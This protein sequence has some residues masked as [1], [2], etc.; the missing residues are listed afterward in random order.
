MIAGGY[1]RGECLKTVELY[2][3]HSNKWKK[4]PQMIVPR[5]RF[6]ITVV[7]DRVYAI[8]GCDGNREL[9]SAEEFDPETNSWKMIP[10]CPVTRSNAGKSNKLLEESIDNCSS[11]YY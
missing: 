10:D 3:P 9:S 6:D 1:D 7:N 5:G 8:G 2:D 4:L 11:N